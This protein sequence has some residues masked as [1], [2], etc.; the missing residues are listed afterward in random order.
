[1][2]K[3]PS[4]FSEVDQYIQYALKHIGLIPTVRQVIF[5]ADLEPGPQTEKKLIEELYGKHS[6]CITWN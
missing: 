6:G 2:L 4:E 1:M 5:F 3:H